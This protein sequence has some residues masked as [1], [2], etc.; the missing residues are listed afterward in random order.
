MNYSGFM[1]KLELAYA[2]LSNHDF[3]LIK[4]EEI[5]QEILT[6]S[7][8]YVLAQRSMLTF[9]NIVESPQGGSI[10]FEIH[11]QGSD[12]I[13]N[14]E[15]P[16]YQEHLGQDESKPVTIEFGSYDPNWSQTGIPIKGVNG[17]KFYDH[18]GKFLIWLSPDKF[19]HLHWNKEIEST[20]TGNIK[21]F[22]KFMVH[23]VG[24]STDQ[25]I[26]ERLTGHYTLQ[27]I[28]SIERPLI[29][30][31][32]PTHEIM[33]LL[34]RVTDAYKISILEDDINSFVE[35]MQG[36]NV[37]DK[38]TVSLDAEKAL[39]KLLNPEYNHPSK[40]FSNYPKST[41]GLFKFGF[42]RY[43][44]GIKENITLQYSDVEIVGDVN[45]QI[46]DIIW[47]EENKTI[48]IIKINND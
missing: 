25:P 30:G 34:F 38:K 28:L 7:M 8:L 40:R 47:I 10:C 31:S 2:P 44:Y 11:K 22:T 26:H 12:E 39:V 18:E 17:C 13:L 45:D 21:H 37:P 15:L 36:K 1:S 9:E 35:N 14:C 6:D 27:D 23:Y 4:S 41:D 5:I 32:L 3:T 16:F 19:L 24:K 42:N 29:S 43:I 48:E 46:A 33:L 20:V